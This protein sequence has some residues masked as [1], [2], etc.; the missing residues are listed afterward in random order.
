MH[1]KFKNKQVLILIFEYNI[2]L[3]NI[4]QQEIYYLRLNVI[5]SAGINTYGTKP[6]VCVSSFL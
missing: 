5:I 2:L 1:L 6:S 3:S 4:I